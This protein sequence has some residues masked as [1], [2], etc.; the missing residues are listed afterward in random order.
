MTV[1]DDNYQVARFLT[2]TLRPTSSVRQSLGVTCA[3][4]LSRLR[5]PSLCEISGRIRSE[6]RVTL[7]TKNTHDV[8]GTLA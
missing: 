5:S 4:P 6:I 3:R 7:R 8:S 1:L 2:S